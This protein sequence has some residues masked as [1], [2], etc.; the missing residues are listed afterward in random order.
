MRTCKSY[1]KY[2][3]VPENKESF[4]YG[5]KHNKTDKV[6]NFVLIGCESVDLYENDNL[7][8]FCSIKFINK[9][10][11]TRNFKITGWSLNTLV[12]RNIFLIVQGIY[13]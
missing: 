12:K 10:I 11:E 2:E 8:I 4:M 9:E 6:N 5:F 7:F 1:I 13:F 3:D